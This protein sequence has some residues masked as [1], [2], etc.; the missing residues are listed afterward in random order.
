LGTS[1]RTNTNIINMKVEQL[2]IGNLVKRL[3]DL[4]K[5]DISDL[6]C[7]SE[8]SKIYSGIQLTKDYLKSFG[9]ESDG[10][11]WWD[12]VICLGIYK[13]G[14]YYM[15]TENIYYRIGNEIKYVH[16]LQNLYYSITGSE[17]Q[18]VA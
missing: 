14:I 2:R 5:I 9:F 11:E 3:N 7:I 10:I 6:E 12:G 4:K 18:Y 13:D 1:S 16:Q 17:L 8:N 15:P